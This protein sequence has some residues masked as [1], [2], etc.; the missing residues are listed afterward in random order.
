MLVVGRL[1]VGF[2]AGGGVRIRLLLVVSFFEL[3]R[4][5]LVGKCGIV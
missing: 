2:D 5:C 3:F 4:L 1:G